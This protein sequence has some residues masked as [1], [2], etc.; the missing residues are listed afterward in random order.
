MTSS[1]RL[2][3]QPLLASAQPSHTAWLCGISRA[4]H[5][6][7]DA[8]AVFKDELALEILG[9][10]EAARVIQEVEGDGPRGR[11]RENGSIAQAMRGA[12]A[13]RSRIAEDT[14]CEA[15]SDGATQYVL[16]GA[17]LDTFALR[18]RWPSGLERVFEVDHPATQRWKQQLAER[19]GLQMPSAACFVPV[20]FEQQ[21]FI[22]QL[23]A[24]GWRPDQRTVFSWLGVTMYLAP[25]A[26]QATLARIGNWA[27]P[28]SVLVFDYVRRPS[29][30]D[31]PRRWGLQLMA[32]KFSRMGEPWR[33]FLGDDE[34]EKLLSSNGFD[35]HEFISPRVLMRTLLAHRAPSLLQRGLGSIMGGVARV[36]VG[37]RQDKV[38]QTL[39]PPSGTSQ[40]SS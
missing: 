31:L 19:A 39:T 9:P 1:T 27:A 2:A 13:A 36:R 12:L 17:G 21:D 7:L 6:L 33:C 8:G 25:A 15:V 34:L 29:A 23:K 38:L 5:Q 40:T 10:E 22:E 4:R 3:P 35:T 26:V 11:R 16:L 24:H 37:A 18:D 20:D 28:G 30:M 32:R 14:L